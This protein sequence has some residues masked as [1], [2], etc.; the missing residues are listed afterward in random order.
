MPELRV[1]SLRVHY[2][3]SGEG[4]PLLL[5]AGLGGHVVDWGEEVPAR[6]SRSFRVIRFDNRGAGRTDHPEGPYRIAQMAADAAGVLDALGVETAHVFGVSMGGMIAQHLALDAPE[7][8]RRLV[9]GCTQPGGSQAI[10]ATPEVLA[11]LVPD[12]RLDAFEARW[13][14][15]VILHPEQYRREHE[16][17]LRDYVRRGLEFRAPLRAFQA[18]LDAIVRTHDVMERLHRIR[19]PTLVLTGTED[20]LIPPA[21]SRLLARH[22]PGARLLE[23]PGAGHVFWFSHPEETVEAVEG[24][25]SG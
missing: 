6:L 7:R 8:V 3:E 1:G 4:E 25:V 20:L 22:I 16:E 9:L 5:I 10:P 18:Q 17:E 12:P 19:A 21:N 15:Q 24:F 2:E 11:H 23:I 13:R 14:A